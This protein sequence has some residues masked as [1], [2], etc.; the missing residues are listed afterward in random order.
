MNVFIK[1]VEVKN[2]LAIYK[3]NDKLE[4]YINHQLAATVPLNDEANKSIL[5]INRVGISTSGVHTGSITK[6]ALAQ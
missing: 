2:R 6:I 1:D 3:T 5:D 4:V